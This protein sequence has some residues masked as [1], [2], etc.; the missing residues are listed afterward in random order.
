MD[1]IA[2]KEMT[3]ENNKH[4]DRLAQSVSDVVKTVGTTHQKLEDLVDVINTH[5]VLSERVDNLDKSIEDYAGRM[6]KEIDVIKTKQQ[7]T[8]CPQ[9][10]IEREN[11]NGLGKSLDY[12]RSRIDTHESKI[13]GFISAVTMKWFAAGILMYAIAF[14]THTVGELNRLDKLATEK[15]HMQRG[16]NK[17]N[18]DI[19]ARLESNIKTVHVEQD[20]C[21]DKLRTRLNVLER[22]VDK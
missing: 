14:G 2:Y 9:L 13:D 22:K 1:D 16:L 8:G 10:K 21:Q 17:N 18:E 12:E 6:Y 3:L 19:H 5:N 4:I 20:E 7:D 15:I 11:V